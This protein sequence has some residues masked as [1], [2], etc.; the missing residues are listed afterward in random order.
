MSDEEARGCIET[1][2][3]EECR[4]GEDIAFFGEMAHRT[5]GPLLE[6]GCGAGRLAIPIAR[7]GIPV[8]ALDSSASALERFRRKLE[9]EP[10]AIRS[11]IRLI[12]AD[13]R[14]FS[15]KE[16]F[17]CAICSSNT[18]LLLA[19]ESAI[20]EALACVGSHLEPGGIIVIDVAAIDEEMRAALMRYPG[21]TIPDLVFSG[22]SDEHPLMRA[23]SVKPGS[24]EARGVGTTPRAGGISIR[25]EYF[26]DRGGLRAQ[27]REDLVLLTPAELL[28]LLNEQGFEVVEKFG[29]YDRRPFSESERKLLVAARRLK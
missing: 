19:S 27:R 17:R 23:H 14:R 25:Y 3:I 2:D 21:E 28:R 6:L 9:H 12:R 22:E 11:R 16:R 10:P 24:A 1:L 4:D 26:D 15:L 5:G 20:A 18:L 13:M 7:S 8:T 29:W